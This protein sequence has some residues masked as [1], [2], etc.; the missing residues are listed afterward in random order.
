MAF[1]VDYDHALLIQIKSNGKP[2]S[3]EMDLLKAFHVP[4]F[5]RKELWIFKDYQRNPEIL[6]L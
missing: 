5:C 2:S 6:E 3:S 1:S 4:K